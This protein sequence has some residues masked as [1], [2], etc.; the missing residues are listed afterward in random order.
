M[1]GEWDSLWHSFYNIHGNKKTIATR[2]YFHES[3]IIDSWL[4][5]WNIWNNHPN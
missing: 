4:V 1:A 5:V 2:H 3:S